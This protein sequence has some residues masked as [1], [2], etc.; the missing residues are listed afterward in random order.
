MKERDGFS[1]E[2]KGARKNKYR[3]GGLWILKGRALVE[4][5]R[6]EARANGKKAA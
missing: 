6:A 2:K 5:E 1:T 4:Q 3:T